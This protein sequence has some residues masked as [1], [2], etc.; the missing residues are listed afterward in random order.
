MGVKRSSSVADSADILERA[1]FKTSLCTLR[2]CFDVVARGKSVT[3]FI[4]IASN[5]DA[6]PPAHLKSLKTL[7]NYFDAHPL[8]IGKSTKNG[9]MESGVVYSR[10]GIPT[11]SVDT[12]EQT[13]LNESPPLVYVD[14]GGLYVKLE[15]ALL[16]AC[17]EKTGSSVAEFAREIGISKTTLYEYERSQ[18]GVDLDTAFRIESIVNKPLAK[19]IDLLSASDD[20]I[21]FSAE[22]PKTKFEKEVFD[23][24]KNLGLTF[25]PTKSSPFDAVIKEEPEKPRLVMLT[26]ISDMKLRS[27]K[28]RIA[29]V[30]EISSLLEKDAFFVLDSLHDVPSIDGVP[31]LNKEEIVKLNDSDTMLEVLLERKEDT[32]IELD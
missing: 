4:K 13:M 28:R 16:Q 5:I 32:T 3:F 25:S 20:T 11:I 8:I 27:V 2:S 24:F 10:D 6:M 19:P 22:P 30:Y 26:G 18:R 23:I 7:C 9:E 15:G 31:I 14:K 17:R 29:V 12:L 21:T 1:G